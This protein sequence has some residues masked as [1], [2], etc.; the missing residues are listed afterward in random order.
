MAKSNGMITGEGDI[1]LFF[2]YFRFDPQTRTAGLGDIPR[3]S[4]AQGSYGNMLIDATRL[5]DNKF[6]AFAKLQ[7]PPENV[8]LYLR[9]SFENYSMALISSNY[10][11]SPAEPG[12]EVNKINPGDYSVFVDFNPRLT[13]TTCVAGTLYVT[14]N[15]AAAAKLP[16]NCP[17]S[18]I[19]YIPVEIRKIHRATD[20]IEWHVEEGGKITH[21]GTLGFPVVGTVPKLVEYLVSVPGYEI[22]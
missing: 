7:V 9:V 18:G 5:G 10:V 2:Q 11:V 6:F 16:I 12:H 3:G 13:A 19:A 21:K 17:P 8:N 4:N 22:R 14:R 15:G 1:P 20:F